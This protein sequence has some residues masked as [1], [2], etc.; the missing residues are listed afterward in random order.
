MTSQPP[1]TDRAALLRFRSRAVAMENPAMF[2]HDRAIVEVQERLDLVNRTF[3]SPVIV[4]GFPDQWRDAVP[5]AMVI[6]DTD[7]LKLG[8]NTHDLVIHA[9]ALHWANDPVGQLIQAQLALRP[10]GLFLAIMPG[11]QTLT[12]LRHVFTGAEAAITGGISPRIA[13]MADIRDLGALLQRSGFALPVADVDTMQVSYGSALDLMRD[14]RAMGETNAQS[15]RNRRMLD[16]RVLEKVIADYDQQ[17]GEDGKIRAT[18]ELITLTGWGP[19]PDQPKPLKRGSA[20][21]R[22]TDILRDDSEG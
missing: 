5:G 8:E 18:F 7:N 10:D 15:S 16:R 6:A 2:L 3:T 20:T 14:L 11:G 21:A 13:P 9:M 17:F 22:L 4:T 12:E 19:A 1:L